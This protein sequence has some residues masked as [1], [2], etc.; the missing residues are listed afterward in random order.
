MN[1]IQTHDPMPGPFSTLKLVVFR[2]GD[3]NRLIETESPWA[4]KACF[5]LG[6]IGVVTDIII[7]RGFIWLTNTVFSTNAIVFCWNPHNRSTDGRKKS[8]IHFGKQL[9][10][11]YYPEYGLIK[12]NG[13]CFVILLL[14]MSWM[15]IKVLNGI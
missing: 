5:E 3:I 2:W 14:E 13:L 12:E 10:P 8:R 4:K 15:D 7:R 11:C 9:L 6:M 1:R